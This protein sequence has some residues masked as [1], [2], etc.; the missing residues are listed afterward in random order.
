M[1]E[2]YISTLIT[3]FSL[4]F[5]VKP[6]VLILIGLYLIFALVITRQVGLMT[7]FLGSSIDPV[8]KLFAWAHFFVVVG[9]F[10]LV[11]LLL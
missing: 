10:I 4:L 7:A 9:I 8:L 1:S 2:D 3:K 11:L 6:A 5:I